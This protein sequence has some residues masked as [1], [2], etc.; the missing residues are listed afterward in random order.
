MKTVFKVVIAVSLVLG[1]HYVAEAYVIT[2]M[3]L[4]ISCK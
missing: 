4:F 1:M 3:V 2:K